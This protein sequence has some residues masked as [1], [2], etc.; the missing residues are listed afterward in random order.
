[1]FGFQSENGMSFREKEKG[2]FVLGRISLILHGE[3]GRCSQRVW[4]W[5]HPFRRTRVSEV[6]GCVVF[7]RRKKREKQEVKSRSVLAPGSFSC[8]K[9]GVFHGCIFF[10]TVNVFLLPRPAF[11]T[12]PPPI[13]WLIPMGRGWQGAGQRHDLREVAGRGCAGNE[14]Q[15]HIS[16]LLGH[17][18][19]EFNLGWHMYLVHLLNCS[20]KKNKNKKNTH[21]I[22]PLASTGGLVQEIQRKSP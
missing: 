15:R 4:G 8:H 20:K 22:L 21:K 13:P 5:L 16:S 10:C 1:M 6:C 3:V 17:E 12:E 18:L 9:A 7:L 11:L 14:T 2:G 19:K